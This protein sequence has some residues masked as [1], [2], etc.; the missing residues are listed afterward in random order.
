MPSTG[1]TV[2]H[3]RGNSRDVVFREPGIDLTSADAY[4]WMGTKDTTGALADTVLVDK[5]TSSGI[6]ITY[7]NGASFFT[8]TLDPADTEDLTAGTYF[9]QITVTDSDGDVA[10]V[11]EGAFVLRAARPTDVI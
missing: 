9:H 5:T 3:W 7:S 2:T 1:Q 4:W 11:S 10:T 6:A 8:V